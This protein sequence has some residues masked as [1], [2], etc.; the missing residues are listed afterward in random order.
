M[1]APISIVISTLDSEA[2]LPRTLAA[3]VEGLHAGLIRELVV[4][5]GGSSLCVDGQ[6]SWQ[7]PDGNR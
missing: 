7:T 2:D 5:D 3:L 1:P 6:G 4:A